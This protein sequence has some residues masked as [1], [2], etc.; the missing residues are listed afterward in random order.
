MSS[1]RDKGTVRESLKKT[2]N[3]FRT[4]IP[5]LLGVLLLISLITTAI[6]KEFYG[7]IFTDNLIADSLIGSVVGSIAAGNPITSYVIGGELLSQGVSLAIVTAFILAWV[8]VGMVQLPAESLML[9][10]RFALTRNLI[11][12]TF[13]IIIATL[14]A[15][16][17]GLIS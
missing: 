2:V 16:T 13:C 17:M 1:Q 5:I 3:S 11:S 12:F 6:P 10:K 8:T 9:G 14:M 15:F 7:R 4:F